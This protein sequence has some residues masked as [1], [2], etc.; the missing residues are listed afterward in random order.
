[1][2]LNITA[3]LFLTM[4]AT[5]ALVLI[6]HSLAGRISFQRGFMDYLNEQGLQRM[7]ELL[8]RLQQEYREQGNWQRLQGNLPALGI[9]MRPE[10]PPA[11]ATP[12][13]PPLSDQTGAI[14]RLALLH[15]DYSLVTGNPEAGRDAI[16]LPVEVDGARV[17]WLALVP[18]QQALAAGEVRFYDAQLRAWWII[19]SSAV[20]LA[21]LL[22]WLMARALLRRLHGVT[23]ATRRLAEG[24]FTTRVPVTTHDEL[25]LLAQSF[26]LLAQGLE[27]NESARRAFMAD[28]AHELRTPLAV[29][30]A[31]LEAIQ[32]GIRTADAESL[33][34]LHQQVGQLG[35]LI[36][37]LHE[38]SLTDAG[39][40]AYRHEPIDLTTLLHTGVTGMITRFEAA[41]L[42]LH[43]AIPAEPLRLVGDERRL[44]QLLANLLNNALRHTDA[45]GQVNLA[46]T[47]SGTGW[48]HLSIE[49]SAPGVPDDKLPRLFER[50]YRVD[51][52]RN[53]SSGGSGLGLAICRNIVEAH[54]GHISASSSPLGGLRISIELPEVA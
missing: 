1:M 7:H 24:N 9:L 26:N 40:L 31:E 34:A 16:L 3:K 27:R 36:D 48:L 54:G 44:Q 29:M 5:C 11:H 42:T 6:I 4:L 2:R 37:D 41:R 30:R 32:D 52:S 20:A 19:G 49:D 15:P 38:L 28:I 12:Q 17:G 13:A 10:P 47:R 8:P 14:F 21:A 22:A 53:R 51:A 46:C 39:T 25:G 50:F 35:Q 43:A 18:F 45:G 23:G 33:A